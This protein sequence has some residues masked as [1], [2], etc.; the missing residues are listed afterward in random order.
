MEKYSLKDSKYIAYGTYS[1]V[2]EASYNS[3]GR[4][5]VIKIIPTNTPDDL[6]YAQREKQI[7]KEIDS[8]Y[9]VAMRDAF[10]NK[11]TDEEHAELPMNTSLCIVFDKMACDLYTF[12]RTSCYR[13]DSI[14]HFAKDILNGLKDIHKRN[15]A[16]RD[17][18]S[19]N[20]LIDSSCPEGNLYL[21]D[22]GS[23]CYVNGHGHPCIKSDDTFIVTT[24]EYCAPEANNGYAYV[25]HD[26]MPVYDALA[27]DMWSFGCILFELICGSKCAFRV[28]K[29]RN[30]DVVDYRH[31]SY[32]IF[33]TVPH[34]DSLYDIITNAK[35]KNILDS[36]FQVSPDCPYSIQY[37]A[38]KL[39]QQRFKYVD[40]NLIDLLSNTLH[41]DPNKRLTASQALQHPYFD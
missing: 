26:N 18:K 15:I 24:P 6:Y 4:Q 32:S 10:V 9:C 35:M 5:C 39:L 2:Y 16:H 40:E 23:A 33:T 12:T 31:L 37:K 17:L 13:L 36:T 3:D 38:I 11:T 27:A 14:K 1:K 20:I 21:A 28:I 25:I 19:N 22:F 7:L 34:D 8:I 41:L 29:Y 30:S